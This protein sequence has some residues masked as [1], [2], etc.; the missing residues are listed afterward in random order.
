VI[1]VK[2]GEPDM[3]GCTNGR[4]LVVADRFDWV[5]GN[6]DTV[7]RPGRYGALPVW[8]YAYDPEFDDITWLFFV[9]CP[10]DGPKLC[11]GE[12]RG[13]NPQPPAAKR[14]RG[15]Y[16]TKRFRVRRGRVAGLSFVPPKRLVDGSVRFGVK[17]VVLTELPDAGQLRVERTFK[18]ARLPEEGS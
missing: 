7:R 4:D 1:A 9:G 8:L 3:V 11:A 2:D 5:G 6:C 10:V 14:S 18:P 17:A 15:L 16:R 12:L 13:R